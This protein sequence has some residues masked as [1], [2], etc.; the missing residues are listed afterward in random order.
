MCE[1]AVVPV[2]VSPPARH[3][4]RC[5]YAAAR[6][7]PAAFL[8]GFSLGEPWMKDLKTSRTPA[9]LYDNHIIGNPMTT[10][11][12]IDNEEGMNLAIRHRKEASATR[13]SAI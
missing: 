9:A 2:D 10:Y 8:L 7:L 6:F 13:R 3:L 11:V 4:L 12:G 1:V 5:V